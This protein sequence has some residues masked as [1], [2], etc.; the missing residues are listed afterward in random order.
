MHFVNITIQ[1]IFRRICV[2]S[3]EQTGDYIYS[4]ICTEFWQVAFF[5]LVL[6]QYVNQSNNVTNLNFCYVTLFFSDSRKV[7]I[8]MVL[9]AGSLNILALQS[10]HS[11]SIIAVLHTKSLLEHPY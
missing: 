4:P 2:E 11:G 5:H 1:V 8:S 9:Y 3:S 6:S 7:N 10:F